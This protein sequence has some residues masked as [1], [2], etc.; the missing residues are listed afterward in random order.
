VADQ[1]ELV[2]A[3]CVE[4]RKQVLG[5]L[6]RSVAPPRRA[7]PAEAPQ[8]RREHAAAVPRERADKVAERPPVQ[9]PTVDEDDRLAVRI[10]R[11]ACG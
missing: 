10:A 1:V 4:Q 7:A 8:I 5:E 3:E 2:E 11:G 9:R 6:R